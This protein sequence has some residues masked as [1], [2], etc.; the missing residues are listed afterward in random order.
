MNA[1]HARLPLIRLVG[2]AVLALAA[3]LVFFVGAPSGVEIDAPQASTGARLAIDGNHT[4]NNRSAQ[5]A[6]QQSVVNGWTSNAYLEL[7]SEQLDE[8]TAHAHAAGLRSETD[9]RPAGLLLI[10]VLGMF[11][12]L[13]TVSLPAPSTAALTQGVPAT[14][15]EAAPAE[16]TAPVAQDQAVVAEE[17]AAPVAGDDDPA[18]S[19][20]AAL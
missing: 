4:L 6:P 3:L 16:E 12:H 17:Q 15:T 7:I 1:L 10:G 13:A 18:P 5:G 8:V 11:F 19:Q 14:A 20:P 9:R 2:F